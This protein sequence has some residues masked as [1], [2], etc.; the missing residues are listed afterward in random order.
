MVEILNC[1]L[2]AKKSHGAL[3]NGAIFFGLPC[4]SVHLKKKNNSDSIPIRFG[5]YGSFN[6]YLRIYESFKLEFRQRSQPRQ[7]A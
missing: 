6:T 3:S 2:C 1:Y 5:I 4:T 7:L